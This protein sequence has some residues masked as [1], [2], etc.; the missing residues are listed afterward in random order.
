MTKNLIT[1]K[2]ICDLYL[3]ILILR[4]IRF[5]E[6]RELVAYSEKIIV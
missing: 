4:D 1:T 2:I 5:S 6:R 3:N